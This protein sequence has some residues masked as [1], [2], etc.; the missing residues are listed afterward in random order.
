M[1]KCNFHY[2]AM[3]TSQIL[4]SVDLTKTH[5]YPDISRTKHYYFFK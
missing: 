3:M 5:K 4:K 2:V 1:L